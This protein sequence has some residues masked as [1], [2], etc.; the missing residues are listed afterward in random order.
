[1]NFLTDPEMKMESRTVLNLSHWRCHFPVTLQRCNAKRC[2][3]SVI[4]RK[5]ERLP[6]LLE[7]Q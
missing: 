7:I 6:S 1:M 4:R 5:L 3:A 2:N